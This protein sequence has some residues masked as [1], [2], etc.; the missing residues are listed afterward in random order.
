[1]KNIV[2]DITG[3]V[4]VLSILSI[5]LGLVFVLWPDL[6]LAALGIIVG[7]CLIIYGL[8]LV[9]LDIRA[10]KLYL[11]FEGMLSGI[12]AILL[13]LLLLIQPLELGVF[14]GIAVGLWIILS[15]VSD[16][17]IA[18]SLKGSDA[19]WLLLIIFGL[20]DFLLG[21]FVL[22]SPVLFSLSATV[23]IGVVLI[24]HSILRL[25]DM[26]TVRRNVKKIEKLIHPKF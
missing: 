11:P 26:I 5:L 13:G 7:V 24:V 3:S 6:S 9:I 2:K 16:I 12:L 4:I 23:F 17:K 1:M 20:L 10:R 18:A 21:V 25:V 14:L 15:S 19:P 8:T 22:L